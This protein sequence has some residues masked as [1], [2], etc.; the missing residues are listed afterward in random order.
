MLCQ[1]AFFV[2]DLFADL[3][4][5]LVFMPGNLGAPVQVTVVIWRTSL[6]LHEAWEMAYELRPLVVC[7]TYRRC[8]LQCPSVRPGP[9]RNLPIQMRMIAILAS[10]LRSVVL[11]PSSRALA[12]LAKPLRF[13]GG[14]NIG[15]RRG[16]ANRSQRLE[17]DVC[18]R[19]DVRIQFVVGHLPQGKRVL[20]ERVRSRAVRSE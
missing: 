13:A 7:R 6:A 17:V 3:R 10:S 16:S 4:I 20:F 15:G 2:G 9:S 19:S 1:I 5:P 14:G 12:A 18:G 11:Q 8:Q